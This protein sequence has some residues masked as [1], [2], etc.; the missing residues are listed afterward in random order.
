MPSTPDPDQRGRDVQEM[1]RK[2]ALED[3]DPIGIKNTVECRDEYDAYIGG[4]YRLLVRGAT[5]DQIIEHLD[6]IE[7]QQMSWPR[8]DK[9][10]LRPVAKKL[11]NLNIRLRKA[12]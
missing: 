3:W 5:E 10:T 7:S 12:G 9:N 4:I 6:R 1:I 11:M 8:P 2:V